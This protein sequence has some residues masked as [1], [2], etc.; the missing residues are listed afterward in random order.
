M[1][2]VRGRCLRAHY[3]SRLSTTCVTGNRRTGRHQPAL[4]AGRRTAHRPESSDVAT[5]WDT[6][7][8]APHRPGQ[9]GQ[10]VAGARHPS[11]WTPSS[12]RRWQTGRWCCAFPTMSAR[13]MSSSG[14][15]RIPALSHGARPGRSGTRG[16]RPGER[17]AARPADWRRRPHFRLLRSSRSARRASAGPRHYQPPA[18][19]LRGTRCRSASPAPSAARSPA[20]HRQAAGVLHGCKAGQLTAPAAGVPLIHLEIDPEEVGRNFA[21]SLPLIA[22]AA[23]GLDAVLAASADVPPATGW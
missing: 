6:A 13:P 2:A 22:D 23:V 4:A 15:C 19:H 8:R 11:H 7:A 18:H 5:G 21:D 12:A 17:T 10:Q 20:I 1:S 16:G 9:A 14:H 3:R